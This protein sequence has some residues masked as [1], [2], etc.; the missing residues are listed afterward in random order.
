MDADTV[1]NSGPLTLVAPLHRVL[2][3]RD[4]IVGGLFNGT[5]QGSTRKPQQH[6]RAP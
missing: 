5:L 4:L 3:T 1:A 2:A 6:H